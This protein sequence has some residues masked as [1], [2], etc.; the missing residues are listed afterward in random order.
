[1]RIPSTASSVRSVK[2]A[3]PAIASADLHVRLLVAPD[4]QDH[5]DLLDLADSPAV[6]E[7]PDNPVDLDNKEPHAQLNNKPASSAQLELADLPDHLDQLEEPDIPAALDNLD[8]EA[9]PDHP[10]HVDHL[11]LLDSPDIPEA[12]A[13]P[14]NLELLALALLLDLDPKDLPAQLDTLVALD[15]PEDLDIPEVKD[16]PDLLASLDTPDSPVEM[17]NLEKLDR[18]ELMEATQLTA[19]AHRAALPCLPRR[20]AESRLKRLLF[21]SVEKPRTHRYFINILSFF[22][23]CWF[24][25][26]MVLLIGLFGKAKDKN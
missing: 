11:D 16:S 5:L 25:F 2:E 24:T 8:M 1:V 10:D 18:L 23:L 15:N 4:L 14:E 20:V 7:K 3:C 26:D 19:P 13:S 9:A 17:V 12:L 21:Q 22:Y 6:P